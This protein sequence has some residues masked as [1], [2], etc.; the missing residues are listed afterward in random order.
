MVEREYEVRFKVK[1]TKTWSHITNN[2]SGK[3]VKYSELN[4]VDGVWYRIPEDAEITDISPL[5]EG[6][7]LME[8]E[9]NT[10]RYL[11]A[12]PHDSVEYYTGSRW[13][14]SDAYSSEDMNEWRHLTT[15]LGPIDPDDETL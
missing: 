6:Y 10:Y 5:R 12:A 15:F 7:Y 13:V 1:S 2:I 9:P 14:Q 3:Q 11:T 4:S 8:G